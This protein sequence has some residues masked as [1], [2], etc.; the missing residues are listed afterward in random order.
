LL[1]PTSK[2]PKRDETE[3]K[4]IGVTVKVITRE[5]VEEYGVKKTTGVIV[6]EVQRGSLAEARQIKPGDIIT[7][8]NRK[9]VTTPKE[10]R[11]ALEGV[12][13]K[14]GVSIQLVGDGGKRFEF[15][16]ESGD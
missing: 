11:E 2:I 4:N 10:F 14:K 7:K 12:D 8:V 9:S 5:L 15:L 1:L 6:T 13:L 3:S 16:K